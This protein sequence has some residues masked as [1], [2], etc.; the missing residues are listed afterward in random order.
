MTAKLELSELNIHDPVSLRWDIYMSSS[1][2]WR[3]LGLWKLGAFI[4][5]S[6]C[7]GRVRDH[8][9]SFHLN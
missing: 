4:W 7:D 2:P 8:M 1:I 6:P 3:K 9:S 5:A